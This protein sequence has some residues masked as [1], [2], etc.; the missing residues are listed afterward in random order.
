MYSGSN[1]FLIYRGRI[2]ELLHHVIIELALPEMSAS[3]TTVSESLYALE[4]TAGSG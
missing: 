4:T 1:D 2:A 3:T